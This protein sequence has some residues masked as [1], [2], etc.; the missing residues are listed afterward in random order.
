MQD[1]WK[2]GNECEEN[3]EVYNLIDENRDFIVNL[4]CDE[5]HRLMA[6]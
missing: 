3:P 1:C 6:E 4:L 5:D 2:N